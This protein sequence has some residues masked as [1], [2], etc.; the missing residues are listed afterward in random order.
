[1]PHELDIPASARPDL[2]SD[3]RECLD[4]VIVLSEATLP[5]RSVLLISMLSLGLKAYLS[6]DGSPAPPRPM[7]LGKIVAF[8]A[9]VFSLRASRHLSN[10]GDLI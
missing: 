3:P 7:L 2:P 1:M 4:H 9:A 10:A 6:M 5:M 8:L